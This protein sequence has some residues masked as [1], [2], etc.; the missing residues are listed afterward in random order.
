MRRG[1]PEPRRPGAVG[2]RLDQGRDVFGIKIVSTATAVASPQVK[3][4][5]FNGALGCRE[6]PAVDRAIPGRD[7]RVLGS[8]NE[9]RRQAVAFAGAHIENGSEAFEQLLLEPV[10][11]AVAVEV[12]RRRRRY[13]Q[14]QQGQSQHVGH[15]ITLSNPSPMFMPSPFLITAAARTPLLFEP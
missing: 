9:R 5:E 13:R 6:G 12:L 7:H 2:L 1:I 8:G 10:V 4:L 14:Q 15:A 3:I 11:Q